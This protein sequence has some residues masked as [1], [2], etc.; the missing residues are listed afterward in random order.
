MI[1]VGVIA[2]ALLFAGCQKKAAKTTAGRTAV[3]TQAQASPP[4]AFGS[5]PGP[6]LVIDE[7]KI[8]EGATA[9]TGKTVTVHYTGK[10]TNGTKFDSSLDR[11]EPFTF[12]LGAGDVIE[13]WN[14]G[15]V[16]MK[17]GGKRRLTIPSE[18][19]YGARGK[20]KIPPNATLIFEVEL[21]GVK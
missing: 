4:V 21:L 12:T 5:K 11:K 15:L 19:G 18:L 8:G 9:E 20:G 6:S 17:V 16:G 10:L 3:Q 2:L 1:I 7:L 14:K 13:G